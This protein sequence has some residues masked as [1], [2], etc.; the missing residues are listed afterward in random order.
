MPD[1][2]P[3]VLITRGFTDERIK[4]VEEQL[5]TVFDIRFA[6]NKWILGEEFCESLGFTD[7]Q[8]ND[9][10]FNMLEALGATEEDAEA[11]NDYICGTMTIEGAPHLKLE[12]LPIFDCASRCGRKGQ[13]FINHM[14]HVHMMSAVQ[15]LFLVP[16]PKQSICPPRPPLMKSARYTCRDGIT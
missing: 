7:A 9:P 14:A 11:A 16:Y 3:S 15:P 13:R 10:D 12:H 5:A 6:F 2:Q 4:A 8:L 1:H